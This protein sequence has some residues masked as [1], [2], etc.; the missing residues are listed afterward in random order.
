MSSI[1][2]PLKILLLG[3]A[4]NCHRTLAGA[5]RSM[6]HNVVLAS[7]GSGWMETERD[8]DISRA[9][10]TF[11]GAWLWTR[12]N[13]MKWRRFT[14]YDIVVVSNPNFLDLKPHRT[15]HFFNFIRRHN[16]SVFLTALGTDIPFLDL[17]ND[18]DTPLRYSEWK[19]GDRPA[20]LPLADPDALTRWHTAPMQR[21]N[22]AVYKNIDGAVSVLYE[23]DL[24]LRRVLPSRSI[25]YG[26]IPIDTAAITPVYI[27]DRPDR[28]RFF[29]GIQQDRQFV[30]GTDRLLAAAKKILEKYPQKATLDVVS[31]LPYSVYIDRMSSAHVVLD[32]LYSYTPATNALLA[33]AMGLSAFSGNEPEYYNFIGENELHPVIG[34]YP[35]DEMIFNTLENIVLHPENLSILGRQGRQFVMRHNDSHI[36][37]HRFLNFWKKKI[38]IPTNTLS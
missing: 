5:L 19:I 1:E 34:C 8:I 37:A 10:G 25:A 26:G 2:N 22:N 7:N 11:S 31:N 15:Q 38:D 13:T 6:G 33:M 36:V 32:Q 28:V 35:D 24:A 27:P 3:D 21:L 12:L 16:R 23:Y 14:G 4:S 9:P 30:K 29:I 20:P 18:P 17:C